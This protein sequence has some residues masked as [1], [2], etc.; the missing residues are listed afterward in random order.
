MTSCYEWRAR[1]SYERCKTTRMCWPSTCTRRRDLWPIW[2]PPA[3]ERRKD[4]IGH[5]PCTGTCFNMKDGHKGQSKIEKREKKTMKYGWRRRH[6]SYSEWMLRHGNPT[7]R[8]SFQQ[9]RCPRPSQSW[10]RVRR[11]RGTLNQGRFCQR[12][13]KVSSAN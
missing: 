8:S 13:S 2:D 12:T 9:R 6:I 3:Y 11:V 1:R 5:S 4:R 10:N 7:C